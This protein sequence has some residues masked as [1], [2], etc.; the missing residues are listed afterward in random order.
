MRKIGIILIASVMV[1]VMASS[2]RVVHIVTPEDF[3]ETTGEVSATTAA[4]EIDLNMLAKDI[5]E[6]AA[7]IKLPAS[8][9][10]VSTFTAARASE[11]K[12]YS[13]TVIFDD[14][15]NGRVTIVSGSMEVRFS[16]AV[17]GS[18]FTVNAF[19]FD[20]AELETVSR[21][22]SYTAGV[23]GVYGTIGAV[24]P[25][26]ESGSTVI[27]SKG[28]L[29]SVPVIT[30]A[31]TVTVGEDTAS[32]GEG[33]SSAVEEPWYSEDKTEFILDS[34]EDIISFGNIVSTG[35][36]DFEGDTV[37]L[38][39]GTYDLSSYPDFMIGNG[40]RKVL[41]SSNA[42]KGEFEGNGSIIS[43]L[44]ID[45]DGQGVDDNTPYG[46][47]SIALNAAIRNL[48][49]ENCIVDSNT[50]S[51]GIA[52]GYAKNTDFE[53]IKVRSSAVI[54]AEG[55]GG[56]AGRLIIDDSSKEFRI[57][58]C[59]VENTSVYA[60]SSYHAGGLIGY[61]S[62]DEKTGV[63]V[64]I[65][66]NQ[67]VMTDPQIEISSTSP[68]TTSSSGFLMGSTR[69]WK[70]TVFDFS[71][72]TIVIADLDQIISE[73]TGGNLIYKGYLNGHNFVWTG[74]ETIY[75]TV[76][77]DQNN[78]VRIGDEAPLVI[79]GGAPGDYSVEDGQV[80]NLIDK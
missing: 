34:V 19:A 21:N 12:A 10:E 20:D 8:W 56:I 18:K 16:G 30:T 61:L 53:N 48:S 14:Y 64:E 44:D 69:Q 52:V 28:S 59:I 66:Q 74:S 58:G 32:T 2:C 55:S 38:R 75:I 78:T 35:L 67:I 4:R 17:D 33:T 26:N 11:K 68:S 31:G 39:A 45:A 23:T 25:I 51:T 70:G 65:K 41:D 29:T 27:L 80:D 43:G 62:D 24:M 63:K 7:G 42:F 13:G 50:S 57:T 73:A 1:L 71:E 46:F 9:S 37:E 79:V 3:F 72:N 40:D 22:R 76:K 36:D 77:P 15:D 5:A 60:E 47:F 6:E 54:G 49:F